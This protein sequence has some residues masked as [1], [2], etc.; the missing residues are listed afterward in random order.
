MLLMKVGTFP[1]DRVILLLK[2][3][4]VREESRVL[5][6]PNVGTVPEESTVMLLPNVVLSQKLG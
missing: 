5:L 6:L 2:V 4:T 1:E 3:G